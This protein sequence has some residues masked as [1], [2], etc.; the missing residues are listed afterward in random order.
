MVTFILRQPEVAYRLR[1]HP[2]RGSANALPP[3]SFAQIRSA[4][5]DKHTTAEALARAVQ[6]D[7]GAV[8]PPA[9]Q[10]L[11]AAIASVRPDLPSEVVHGSPRDDGPPADLSADKPV[12]A[13]DLHGSAEEPPPFEGQWLFTANYSND[14][15]LLGAK[16]VLR[17]L[18]KRNQVQFEHV[19]AIVL[20][21]VLATT[22]GSR[23]TAVSN[24]RTGPW[25]GFPKRTMMQRSRGNPRQRACRRLRRT[26]A[27]P[28]G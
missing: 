8:Q 24:R 25:S 15:T 21:R 6:R 7:C 4:A 10:Q 3:G 28:E 11:L 27:V 22:L 26:T 18:G 5:P 12:P 23:T 14:F 20:D 9:S 13:D 19:V 16:V 2:R 17:G 1:R